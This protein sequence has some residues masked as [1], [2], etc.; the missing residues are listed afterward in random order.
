[1]CV[2]IYIYIYIYIYLYIYLYIHIL[3]LYITGAGTMRLTQPPSMIELPPLPKNVSFH[4]IYMSLITN[5]QC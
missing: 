5:R 3:Y 4:N 1:M 2:C